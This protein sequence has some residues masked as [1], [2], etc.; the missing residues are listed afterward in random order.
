LKAKN[1]SKDLKLVPF[2][3]WYEE[4]EAWEARGEYVKENLVRAS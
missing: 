3:E 1:G 2:S 4:L